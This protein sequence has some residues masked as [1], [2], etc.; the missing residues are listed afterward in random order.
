MNA[1]MLLLVAAIGLAAACTTPTTSTSA[2]L[3]GTYDLVLVDQVQ[4]DLLAAKSFNPDAVPYLV[5]GVPARYLF[6]TSTE[7]N[8]LRILE[9]YRTGLN[10]PGFVRAP[11]PLETLSIPVLD[12]PTMLVADEG[13]NSEGSRVTGA[14]VYAARPG[15]AEVSV[16][17]VANRTQLGGRPMATPGPVTALG[18]FMDVDAVDQDLTTSEPENLLPATTRLFVAT[19]DG[20]FASV[21]SAVLPTDSRPLDHLDFKRLVLIDQTPVTALLVV[22]PLSSRTLDGAPFCSTKACLALSTRQ[23]SGSGG[24]TML[25]DPET[26]ISARLAFKGPVRELTNS[27]N[28]A[29]IYGVL[30]EQACGG[31]ACGGVAAVDLTTATSAAGF[32]AALD[33]L[34]QPMVPLRSDGLITGL[35][36]AAGG[37]VRQAIETGITDGGTLSYVLQQY[38]ELGA[39]SSSNGLITYFSGFGGS[40]IDFDGRR[41]V[42]GSAT[43]RLPGLLP[44]GGEALFGDDGGILGSN[45]AATVV[46]GGDLSQTWR[47]ATVTTAEATEWNLDISDGYLDTQSIAIIYQG[48]IPGLTSLPTTATA[49]THL[50]TAGWEVR[51]TIGD[52]VRLETGND[53]DGYRECGRS[54]IATIGSGFIEIAEVPAGC[55][56]RARFSVRADGPRP[57]VAVGDLEGYMGRWAPGDTL[58]YNRPYVL[59]PADVTQVRTALTINIPTG[60][61]RKEGSFISF[62]IFGRMAPLQLTVDAV[63]LSCYAQLAGQV[64]FGNLVMAEV[65]TSVDGTASMGFRWLTYATVP[66]GNS[67]A[68]F[69][70]LLPTRVGPL[71]TNDGAI[72][73]R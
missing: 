36:V 20:E 53:T 8:E 38:Q 32:P 60:L 47:T 43:V 14:Y 52:I 56:N 59:L 30:D 33:A 7:T 62:E 41:T 44:D 55:E 71:N 50:L 68:E 24:Q 17:S 63:T 27:T 3:N 29:R 69:N 18:A 1:R 28:A 58:T 35:T 51:A 72:C 48:Q 4:G 6:V 21:Y 23:D 61:P 9:N 39:F 26:G 64:V 11:N 66:S 25:L 70:M 54:R 19:W 45:T 5:I 42:V 16:V 65:P 34:G 13:R 10:G 12:R 57:L 46:V 2:N 31:P 37:T 73:R 67:V 49:G 15:A 22:A 40:I